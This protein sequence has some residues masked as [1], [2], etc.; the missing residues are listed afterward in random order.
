MSAKVAAALLAAQREFPTIVKDKLNP[1]HKSRYATL[2]AVLSATLP[3]LHKHGL[4][5]TQSV[6]SPDRDETGKMTAFTIV[7]TLWHAESGESLQSW[8]PM[9]LAKA[10]PQGAGAAVTYAR[11]YGIQ[12]ALGVTAD[13]DDDG[14]HASR[15][16]KDQARSQ[17]EGRQTRATAE[18]ASHAAAGGATV[19]PFGEKKGTPLP[20]LSQ[21]ELSDGLDWL[22]TKDAAK[23]ASLITAV[24]TEL[25]SRNG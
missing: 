18:A 7:T 22:K 13:E 12:L 15:P 2:D 25:D 17:G 23:F 21:K 6:T 10:D 14:N 19:W 20:M 1:F 9:P 24:E 5:L 3:I 4:A 11:R 16:A 8:L